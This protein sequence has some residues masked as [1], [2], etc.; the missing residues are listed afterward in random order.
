MFETAWLNAFDARAA[1]VVHAVRGPLM[2]PLFYGITVLANT[3]PVVF[4]TATAVV[5]LAVRRRFAS[6]LL[7]FAVVAGGEAISTTLK[8]TIAR[9][10]PPAVDALIGLP[11]DLSFPSGH[12]L[13]AML[14]YGVIAF[15]L[16]RAAATRARRLA[17]TS[18]AAVLVFMVGASRVYLG[19]HWPSDVVGGWVIGGAWLAL[20]ATVYVRL[21]RR[22]RTGER[23]G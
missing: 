15:L 4:V 6:A 14:L 1:D 8:R 13:A 11:A 18:A 17:I 23:A 10:R 7:V 12:A 3:G 20:C 5:V 16:A 2:T 9:Q 22:E 19:V 21:E